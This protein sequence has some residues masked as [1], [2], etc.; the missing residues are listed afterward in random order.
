MTSSNLY[1]SGKTQ[2]LAM[3]RHSMATP[4][5]RQKEKTS[6]ELK[7]TKERARVVRLYN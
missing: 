7:L 6:D 2:G 1:R 4:K 5:A 3:V